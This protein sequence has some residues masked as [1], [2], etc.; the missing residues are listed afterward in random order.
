MNILLTGFTGNLG[1]GIARQ[2]APHRILALVR[3][4][5]SAPRSVDAELVEG[6]LE[7]LPTAIAG[8]V[9]AIVH[10]AAMTAFRAPL[11]ELRRV[12]VDGTVRLLEFA[13]ACPRL[14]AGTWLRGAALSSAHPRRHTP[15]CR[16]SRRLSPPADGARRRG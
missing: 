13:R 15:H 10:S 16:I 2:L 14:G 5:G 11:Q 7:S 1:P 12:N 9:E 6:S 8:E 3:D 4:A